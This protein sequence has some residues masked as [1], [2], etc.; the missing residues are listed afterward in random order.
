MVF[1]FLFLTYTFI[2]K[3]KHTALCRLKESEINKEMKRVFGRFCIMQAA[4]W[5]FYA[6]LPGYITAYM[7]DQGMSAAT[8]GIL[9]ALQMGA[10]FLG[11]IFWGHLTEHTI[12]QFLY[13]IS[14]IF[15]IMG[16]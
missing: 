5:S 14:Y 11:S 1:F 8:L 16:I 13:F 6:S 15:R 4:Y 3:T 7:L 2:V 10:A 9:L 12:I